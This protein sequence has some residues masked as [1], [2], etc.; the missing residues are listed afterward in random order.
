M[1]HV[2]T[3]HWRSARW[4][5][6]QLRYLERFLTAPFRVYAFLSKVPGDHS[7]KYFYCSTEPITRHATKLNLLGD[8]IGFAAEDPSDLLVFIDG[9]AFPVASLDRLVDE[10]LER[11]RLIAVQRYENNGDLQPHPCFC[12]TTVGFWKEIGGDWHQG[13]K[14]PDERTGK[15]IT[16]VGGNLLGT[17]T[18]AQIDWYPLRRMNTVDAHPLH[19]GLYGDDTPLVYHHGAGFRESPGGR[20]GMLARGGVVLEDGRLARALDRLP[21]EGRMGRIRRRYHPVDRLQTTLRKENSQL[22]DEIL[23]EIDRDENFWHRFA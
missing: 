7:H 8:L 12:V 18:R 5:D 6:V 11:H 4:I 20:V 2:A 9:D 15:L 17:L 22:S 19:F 10:R 1:I 14:W 3:V 16:D 23:V 13:Y 21:S